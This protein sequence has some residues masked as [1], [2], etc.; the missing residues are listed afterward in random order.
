MHLIQTLN[1][2]PKTLMQSTKPYTLIQTL[3]S[4]ALKLKPQ[5]KVLTQKLNP[6]LK[7]KF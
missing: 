6:S 5:C 3:N 4:K 1:L 7:S 2:N